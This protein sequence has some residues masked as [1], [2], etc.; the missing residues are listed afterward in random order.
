VCNT[1]SDIN[2][3]QYNVG[4]GSARLFF[5]TRLGSA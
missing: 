4:G 1:G 5:D 2:V 3:T